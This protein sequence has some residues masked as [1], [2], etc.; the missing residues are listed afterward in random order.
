MNLSYFG[1]V[2]ESSPPLQSA[3][4]AAQTRLHSILPDATFPS[5]CPGY[6]FWCSDVEIFWYNI[7]DVNENTREFP[8]CNIR[9]TCCIDRIS[10]SEGKDISLC[11]DNKQILYKS[12]KQWEKKK[13]NQ[14]SLWSSS[15]TPWEKKKKNKKTHCVLLQGRVV[16]AYL[17]RAVPSSSTWPILIMKWAKIYKDGLYLNL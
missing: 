15:R 16:S 13:K 4:P 17:P 14:N 7:L 11:T 12:W 1:I 5:F 8:T 6:I 9:L 10:S 2:S 3:A